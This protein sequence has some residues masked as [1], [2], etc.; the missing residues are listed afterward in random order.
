MSLIRQTSAHIFMYKFRERNISLF[1]E[2]SLFSSRPRL[3]KIYFKGRYFML[4]VK[5]KNVSKQTF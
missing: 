5:D 4:R 1:S 3:S 2:R